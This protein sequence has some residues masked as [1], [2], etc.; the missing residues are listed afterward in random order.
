MNAK[1]Y[2][3][4]SY[5]LCVVIFI[6]C[7]EKIVEYHD[8]F[9]PG[10]F[11]ENDQFHG[12]IVGRIAQNE[13]GAVAYISQAVVIDSV[14][15]DASNGSFIFHGVLLGNYDLTI[16]AENYRIYKRSNVIVRGGGVEYIGEVDLSTVPDPI[17]SHYPEDRAEII[18]DNRFARLS[19]AI[20]FT[21][22]MDRLSVEKAFMT[23]PPSTGIFYWGYYT[24]SPIYPLFAE[25]DYAASRFNPGA[26]IT[27]YSKIT[28]VTYELSRKDSHVDTTYSVTL[29]TDA[30]DTAGHH[31]RF[32]LRFTFK[33]VQAGYTVYGIQ[34]DPVDG[35]I[36]VS[37]ITY[38]GI[39]VTFPRRMNQT[40]TERALTVTPGD[41]RIVL[42]PSGNLLTI[43]TGG[44]FRADTTY[45]VTIDSTATDLDG[46]P[47]G[48]SFSFSFK[49]APVL[50]SYTSPMNGE[51]FVRSNPAVVM[52]FNT[53]IAKSSVERAFSITPFVPGT[54]RWGTECCDSKTAITFTPSVSLAPNT[55]YRINLSTDVQDVYGTHLRE[56]YAFAFVTRPE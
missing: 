36:D 11:T 1:A 24:R 28:A 43:Y 12:D 27:T 46:H 39:Q 7:K 33:T 19:I 41:N 10:K 47:L 29:S 16:R 13:S 37:L 48:E 20:L 2:V 23:D 4:A 3:V 34:T 53:Y 30:K 22:P 51:L 40:S 17:A 18:Y 31:L 38:S 9:P 54:F 42:W 49:T 8:G 25:A 50:V 55:L 6:S 21:Q 15:I 44:V 32:P 45:A 35:D 26:T 14:H 5:L 52:N 56:P